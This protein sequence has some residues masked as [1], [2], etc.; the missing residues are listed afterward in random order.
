MQAHILGVVEGLDDNIHLTGSI[1]NFANFFLSFIRLHGGQLV[2]TAETN[3]HLHTKSPGS[4]LPLHQFLSR[5]SLM[6]AFLPAAESTADMQ[7]LF[8]KIDS[9]MSF[10]VV[11]IAIVA[12]ANYSHQSMERFSQN[13]AA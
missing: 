7:C 8:E 6:R 4:T 9:I 10:A 2:D 13:W 1:D 5:L 11:I 12:Q 3:F